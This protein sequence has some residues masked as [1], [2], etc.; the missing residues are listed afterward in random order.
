MACRLGGLP[1]APRPGLLRTHSR[2]P[3]PRQALELLIDKRDLGFEAC[4]TLLHDLIENPEPT[5]LAAL[6]VLL[7]AKVGW[8]WRGAW[9]WRGDARGTCMH[10][11]WIA[12]VH[13]TR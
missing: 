3:L 1:P 11:W 10:T 4:R 6:L 9:C 13:K 5:Q 7:R 8:A 12:P 2:A